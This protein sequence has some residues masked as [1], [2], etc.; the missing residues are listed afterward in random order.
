MTNRRT[1]RRQRRATRPTKTRQRR[2]NEK[3]AAEAR[4][5]AIQQAM[6]DPAQIYATLQMLNAGMANPELYQV[7]AGYVFAPSAEVVGVLLEP[8]AALNGF[9]FLMGQCL[10]ESAETIFTAVRNGGAGTT[11]E[12]RIM[13]RQDHPNFGYW[14]RAFEVWLGLSHHEK[15]VFV[16]LGYEDKPFTLPDGEMMQ[17]FDGQT[18][19]EW[20]ETKRRANQMAH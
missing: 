5:I 6:A 11:I 9:W 8:A 20:A 4:A 7:L 1:N 19:E 2:R 17:N 12:S 15:L 10:R 3:F 16:C 18:D 13:M 14:P